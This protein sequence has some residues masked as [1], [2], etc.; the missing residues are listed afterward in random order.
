MAVSTFEGVILVNTGRAIRF[1]G[2]FWGGPLWFPTS[3]LTV[4]E[5]GELGHIV[6]EVRDWLVGKRG[7][8]EFTEYTPEQIEEMDA[9]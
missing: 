3:Q 1:Q 8:K 7:L 4:T 2:Y 9:Q 5:E 6:I